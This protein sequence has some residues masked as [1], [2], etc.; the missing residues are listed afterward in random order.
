MIS[1]ILENRAFDFFKLIKE[2]S[3][4]E[5]IS[6][7]KKEI[8]HLKELYKPKYTR[9]IF[10]YYRGLIND[11]ES[12]LK[13]LF[14]ISN[15]EQNK[16]QNDYKTKL[17]KQHGNLIKIK[18]LEGL[19]NKGLEC[20]E[21]DNINLV[22]LGLCLLTG[23]RTTEILKTASFKNYEK[24]KKMLL[25]KGQ[26]KSKDVGLEYPILILG[27]NAQIFKISLKKVRNSLDLSNVPNEDVIR[28]YKGVLQELSTRTFGEFLGSCSPH[29]L[30]KAYGTICTF[31]YK[32]NNQSNNYFLASI[33]GHSADDITTA[34]SYQKY[35]I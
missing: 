35:F 30:R 19:I 22:V 28:K 31:F 17:G 12:Y 3:K 11:K 2:K 32:P 13:D 33:L 25:F 6:E 29:D 10:T 16:I 24:N 21:S 5:K 15:K 26:L 14:L 8:K 1:K 7:C 18:N 4:S 34:N 27:G 9:T 20:L 23:R